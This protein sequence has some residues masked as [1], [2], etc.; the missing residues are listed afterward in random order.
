M[1]AFR[2]P[3]LCVV[4]CLKIRTFVVSATTIRADY[5]RLFKLWFA[6]K[7][8]P[9]WYQQQ[10]VYEETT[11]S[12]VVICLKIRTFVV[13]ATTYL[14]NT[15]L[16]PQLWFAWKFVPLWYQQQHQPFSYRQKHVVICLKIRTFVVSAT[17]SKSFTLIRIRCDLLENSYLCGIS[18][19]Q[20]LE[21]YQ[22]RGVVIC[23]K[24]RT[25]VVSATTRNSII[26]WEKLL[27]FA[28]KFVPLWYQQQHITIK[29]ITLISCDLLENSYLCGI[30]NNLKKCVNTRL[31]LWFAWKFVPLWYQQQRAWQRSARV[32][33]VICLKIRTFVV[34]A[35][36]TK[37][38][39]TCIISCDLLENS[40]L[41]GISNNNARALDIRARVVICLKIRTFVVS[42]TTFD[43]VSIARIALWFAWK[44]V[45]L[46]YQQQLWITC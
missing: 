17:T 3:L 39:R 36:T 4:I 6:W 2:S 33:V 35:T 45:P 43:S 44:F 15:P 10:H 30:S 29:N 11:E 9:L 25:F 40:Y 42:A 1:L 21:R 14:K 19:N 26:R 46:W 20:R 24:I 34:S 31:K 28:W 12:L 5:V 18:N 41:C 7:F 22:N 38:N 13:S 32:D 16:Q 27:W 8:V 37:I 23:L